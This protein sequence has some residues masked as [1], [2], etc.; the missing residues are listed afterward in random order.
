[1][2][3]MNGIETAKYYE[4]EIVLNV[5]MPVFITEICPLPN[6]QNVNWTERFDNRIDIVQIADNTIWVRCMYNIVLRGCV[7]LL[8]MNQ[9]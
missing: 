3:H 1:M 5:L 2:F 4:T 6:L 7:T 9:R 8:Y